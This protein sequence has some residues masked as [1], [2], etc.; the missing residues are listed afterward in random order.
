MTHPAET[1]EHFS[2][3]I[4]QLCIKA[5]REYHPWKNVKPPSLS[6]SPLSFFQII[7]KQLVEAAKHL[8][9]NSI[10]HRDIKPENILIETGSDVPQVRLID[11]GLSC[12]FKKESSFSV[13]C[14]KNFL[15][16][17]FSDTFTFKQSF[18]SSSRPVCVFQVPL[19][20][21]LQSGTRPLS[22]SLAPPQCGRWVWSCMKSSTTHL[23]PSS[24][25]KTSW[26]STTRCPV[27]RKNDYQQISQQIQYLFILMDHCSHLHLCFS[28]FST[29]CM[30]FLGKC[31]D[32]DPE[33]RP[34]LEQLRLHSWLI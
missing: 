4:L 26:I 17:L 29:D 9:D 33:Q 31:L 5:V 21:S 2:T 12:F 14:G 34:T 6:P 11:F 10:F 1:L 30:D 19:S 20:T 16:L 23:I 22:T 8:E 32:K 25:S 27:V 18:Y 28:S 13:F 24:S 15:V 7:I 3:A